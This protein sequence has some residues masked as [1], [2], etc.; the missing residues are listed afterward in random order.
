M[1]IPKFLASIEYPLI[2]YIKHVLN[3]IDLFNDFQ[4]LKMFMQNCIWYDRLRKLSFGDSKAFDWLLTLINSTDGASSEQIK[5]SK[6]VEICEKLPIDLI[7]S[8]LQRYTI[9]QG[10]LVFI[11]SQPQLELIFQNSQS[12]IVDLAKAMT[13]S[14]LI[15]DMIEEKLLTINKV[16]IPIEC[17]R[18]VSNCI[19]QMIQKGEL[20]TSSFLHFTFEEYEM[21]IKCIEFLG[22]AVT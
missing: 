17:T 4:Q 21:F 10:T 11:T 6:L 5:L 14:T 22:I 20:D 13:C 1:L 15:N 8:Y 18:Y 16:Q 19:E 2:F 7:K 12:C 3:G 9:T